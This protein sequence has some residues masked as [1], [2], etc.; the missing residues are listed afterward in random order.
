M[1][2]LI[3][4]LVEKSKKA[5]HNIDYWFAAFN[6]KDKDY[7]IAAE[8]AYDSCMEGRKEVV[9]FEEWIKEMIESAE[10]AII[11]NEKNKKIEESCINDYRKSYVDF[12]EENCKRF[13]TLTLH[14]FYRDLIEK[15]TNQGERD[16]CHKAYLEVEKLWSK[17]DIKRKPNSR[18]AEDEKWFSDDDLAAL[19]GEIKEEKEEKEEEYPDQLVTGPIYDDEENPTY[20]KHGVMKRNGN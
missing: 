18:L 9:S 15:A 16:A 1:K 12:I 10:E 13:C 11:R 8:C 3:Q 19:Y 4:E 5:G 2:D 17:K 14:D 20:I 6:I 7:E